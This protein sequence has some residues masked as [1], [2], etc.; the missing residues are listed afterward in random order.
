MSNNNQETYTFQIYGESPLL[1]H[2]GFRA[3]KKYEFCKDAEAIK[4]KRGKNITDSDS[5]RLIHFDCFQSFWCDYED[6]VGKRPEESQV[7]FENGLMPDIPLRVIRAAIEKGARSFKE[8][9]KVRSG[10]RVKNVDFHWDKSLGETLVELAMNPRVHFIVPVKVG[11]SKI[12]RTR[13]I[14]RDWGATITVQTD[15]QFVAEEDVERWLDYAGAYVGIGDWRPDKSGD[16][17]R[18]SIKTERPVRSS[19]NA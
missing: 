19:L 15:N 8:G 14:F 16:F 4:K 3:F 2:C 1:H 13:A 11:T 12:L 9:P 18:F 17:G 6:Q 5:E 10:L 7:D